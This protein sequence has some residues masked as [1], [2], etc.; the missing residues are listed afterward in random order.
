MPAQIYALRHQRLFRS[1][2]SALSAV[3]LVILVS[4][5]V[6]CGSKSYRGGYTPVVK[7]QAKRAYNK[8][9]KIKGKKYNP[10]RSYEYTQRGIASYYGG[11]DVFHGR[12][13][14]TGEIFNKNGLTAAH[15]TLPLPSIV[16]VTNMKNGRTI[17]LRINDRGPFVKG[18]I[19]DVS[20]K[21]A[22]L[23]G[24][25]HDGIT[26]VK[27]ECLVGESMRLASR[28]NPKACNPYTL[29]GDY[30]RNQRRKR[31]ASTISVK[32]MV[33][34]KL[35]KMTRPSSGSTSSSRASVASSPEILPP[36]KPMHITPYTANAVQK[37]MGSNASVS[38]ILPR[39]TY[40]QV[41]TYSSQMNA[42][43]FAFKVETRM[44]VPCKTYKV[45]NANPDL[46]RVLMGPMSS[47]AA[48]EKMLHEL[49]IRN[50]TDAFVVVQK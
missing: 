29:Y 9:Y 14:S 40:I 50:V 10:R 31:T 28:Y 7:K 33:N 36:K 41:G 45:E 12:K 26:N 18:R 39:G 23:L 37:A 47:K 38:T 8:S 27:V 5:L 2:S 34:Q 24:F 21:A 1:V 22:K 19:I 35:T 20:E 25:H 43:N 49:K 11:R 3:L 15:K 13:T 44:R 32:Q 17:K 42:N 30:P 4:A 48:T 6:G 16:R 46:Y